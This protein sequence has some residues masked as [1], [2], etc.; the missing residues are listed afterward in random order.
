MKKIATALL[1]AALLPLP[2]QAQDTA[3][4]LVAGMRKAEMTYKECWRRLN[5]D[6][7]FR[8]SVFGRRQQSEGWISSLVPRRVG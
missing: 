2:L 8:L 4:N 7:P 6:R 3:E 1:V 5:L